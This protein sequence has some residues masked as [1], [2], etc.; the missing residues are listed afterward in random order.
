MAREARRRETGA[1]HHDLVAAVPELRGDRILLNA[2][3]DEDVAAHVAGEDEETTRRFRLVAEA[4]DRAGGTSRLCGLGKGLARW[5]PEKDIRGPRP[6]HRRSRGRLRTAHTPRRR[7]RSVL[8]DPRRP[9][10]P[11]TRPERTDPAGRLRGIDRRHLPGSAR[12]R[13][14]P[15][16]TARRRSR[17]LHPGRCRRRRRHRDDLLHPPNVPARAVSY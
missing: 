6:G 13:R 5:Q 10:G 15:R 11:G 2:H 12:R 7:S 1:W 3:S 16:L 17:R 4:L 9:A 8:L 14:Q